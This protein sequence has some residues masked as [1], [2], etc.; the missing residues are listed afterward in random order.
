MQYGIRFL[1]APV[2]PAPN[3][4]AVTHENGTDWD[5]ALLQAGFSLLD[6]CLQELIDA[7]FK[8]LLL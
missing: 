2:V 7:H 8:S 5:T 6:G 4:C 1:Y 3:D